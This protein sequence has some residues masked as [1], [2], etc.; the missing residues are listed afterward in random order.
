MEDLRTTKDDGEMSED[1]SGSGGWCRFLRCY[2]HESFCYVLR[3]AY[4]G[5]AYVCER[6][7]DEDAG[8]NSVSTVQQS[9]VRSLA[10]GSDF[11]LS[12][13]SRVKPPLVK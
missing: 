2:H 13:A 7:D 6:D 8:H 5:T 1:T 12:T 10:P 3:L 9:D 11:C 4:H